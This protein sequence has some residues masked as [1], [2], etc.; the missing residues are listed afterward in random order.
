MAAFKQDFTIIQSDDCA[1]LTL[2]DNSNFSSNTEGYTFSTFDTK[3]ITIYDA[4]ENIL[5]TLPIVNAT[6]VTFTVGKDL[7]LTFIYLLQI[8]TDTPLT[9]TYSKA[10]SC[11]VELKYGK[12]VAQEYN[13]PNCECSGE[14]NTQNT[15]FN[16]IKG[17]KAAQVFASTGNGALSQ[18]LLDYANSFTDTFITTP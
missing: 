17:I 5:S 1:T 6:P 14:D 9:K 7:Y 13:G 8:G 4:S 12:I 15:L 3:T 11:F 18:S 2:A 16:I 10:M